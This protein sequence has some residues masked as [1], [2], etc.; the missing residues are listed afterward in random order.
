MRIKDLI[1]ELLNED[2]NEEIY[3]RYEDELG[4]IVYFAPDGICFDSDRFQSV[5]GVKYT[6]VILTDA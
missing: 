4:R 2:M 3:F 1:S 6:T 5:R